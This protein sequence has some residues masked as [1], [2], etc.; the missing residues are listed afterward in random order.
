MNCYLIDSEENFNELRFPN[1]SDW[2]NWIGHRTSISD[3][4]KPVELEY[5]YGVKSKKNKKFDISQ[6][7]KPLFTISEKALNISG[8]MLRRNGDIL[9]ILSPK[10]FY[11]FHCTNIVDALKENESNVIW[12]DK[13]QGWIAS[14]DK[15]VL[16]KEKIKEQEIFRL[17][18]ANF[19]YTF[20]GEDF[21]NLVISN[22]LKGVCFDRYETIIID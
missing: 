8:E 14:I 7:C 12:L 17:P 10:G 22:N 15:F 1:V 4:W 2:Q 20:F 18:N 11:F 9:D 3:I 16:N 19:R 21:K 13:E 5:I 6:Y